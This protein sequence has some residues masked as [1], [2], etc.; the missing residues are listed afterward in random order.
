MDACLMDPPWMGMGGERHYPTLSLGRIKEMTPAIQAIMKP[1]SWLFLWTTKPLETEAK[2]VMQAYGYE[3]GDS[4]YWTKPNHFGFGKKRI[5]IRRA[6]EILLVGTRG[7]VVSKFRSQPDWFPAPVASH[8]EKP[9]EQYAIVERIVGKEFKGVELFARRK[10]PDARWKFWGDELEEPD[11][12]LAP[13][14]FAV[15]AD[16][17]QN[18]LVKAVGDE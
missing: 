13:W 2:S 18:K 14:G 7:N 1:D 15:P 5:G 10:F 4:I 12:S 3:F 9:F 17:T 11:I 8:S 6:T 16:P